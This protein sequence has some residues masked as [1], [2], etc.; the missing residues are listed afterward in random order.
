[1]RRLLVLLI[2]VLLLATAACGGGSGDGK[3]ESDDTI[4]GLHV[5][6]SFGTAPTVRLDKP[7]KVTK[8]HTDV[9][10]KG[11]GDE[12]KLGSKALLNLYIANGKTGK[13]AISTYDRGQPLNATMDETQFFPPLVKAIKG[14]RGGS[15]VAFADTVKDLYGDA[16]AKQ[17]GLKKTDSLVFVIDV[18]SAAP[19][20]SIDKV[21]GAQIDPPASLPRIVTKG[22]KIR[23]FDFSKAAKPKNKL[24]VVTLVKGTGEKISG[25]KIVD[26]N[27]VGQVFG[28]KKP[29]SNSFTAPQPAS[30]VVGGGQLIPGWDKALQGQRVGTRLMLLVPPAQGYGKAGN[31]QIHVTGKSTLVF[32]MDVLGVG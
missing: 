30:F 2:A 12:V 17:L 24:R 27:F 20:D 26:I 25:Q 32:V 28:G 8:L 14:M 3:S 31:P 18:M 16:G 11:D 13:K 22:G 4:S 1:V 19:S 15:R 6:G 10:T 23:G 29:F 5:A 21:D 7:V 9:I